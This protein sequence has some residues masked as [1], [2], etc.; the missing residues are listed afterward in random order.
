MKTR[1]KLEALTG[2]L[3]ILVI[4]WVWIDGSVQHSSSQP[5]A[6]VNGAS[7]PVRIAERAAVGIAKKRD[8]AD[9]RVDD[10]LTNARHYALVL[11]YTKRPA[12][13]GEVEADTRAIAHAVLDSLMRAG[14]DPYSAKI[15][16]AVWARRPL[17]RDADRQMFEVY[18][19]TNYDT[20]TDELKFAAEVR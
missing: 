9:V 20:A 8:W 14:Q 13:I 18:G 2:L 3:P 12:N 1:S 17:E 15:D 5:R 7:G 16:V 4:L 11:D 6:V 19:V 10:G